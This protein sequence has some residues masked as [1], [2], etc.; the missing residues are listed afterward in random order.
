M[1]TDRVC[2]SSRFANSD[3][4]E[5]W[6]HLWETISFF[7]PLDKYVQNS[8][9]YQDDYISQ[10]VNFIFM[11]RASC[12]HQLG[13]ME[14]FS[15]KIIKANRPIF[16]A[17]FAIYPRHSKSACQTSS[18]CDSNQEWH[19]VN[20]VGGDSELQKIIWNVQGGKGWGD[21]RVSELKYLCVLPSA[22]HYLLLVHIRSQ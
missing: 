19:K 13:A 16:Q 6:K 15:T 22:I 18:Q 20:G 10:A 9:S 1:A 11:N 12:F 21:R 14:Y 7:A 3:S 4:E 17:F 8:F 5:N 2:Q